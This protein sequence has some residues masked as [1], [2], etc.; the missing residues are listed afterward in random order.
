MQ[1]PRLKRGAAHVVS[2]LR[3]QLVADV[4]LGRAHQHKVGVKD[5]WQGSHVAT[6]VQGIAPIDKTIQHASGHC[7]H[8]GGG[9]LTLLLRGSLRGIII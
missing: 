9:V 5:V 7:F 2:E 4:R 3:V 6:L 1:Q 8:C